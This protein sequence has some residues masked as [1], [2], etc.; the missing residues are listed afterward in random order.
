MSGKTIQLR[1]KA[2]KD[3]EQI[4]HY[5]VTRWGEAR[6]ELYISDLN[7]TFE[8]LAETPSIE[9]DCGFIRPNLFSCSVVSHVVFYKATVTG[10]AVIRVLHK[11]MDH[12]RHI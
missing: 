7:D 6:A 5:S 10:I 4:Y 1:P 3:I 12:M 8:V 9:R 2:Y 11:S